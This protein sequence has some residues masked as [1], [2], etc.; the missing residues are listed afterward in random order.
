M[1]SRHPRNK[2]C[3]KKSEKN[4]LNDSRNGRGEAWSLSFFHR[5][6]RG[7]HQ[8]SRDARFSLGKH[9]EKGLGRE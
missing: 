4:G 5:K 7:A 8:A 1:S 6:L 3:M 2:P 9:H